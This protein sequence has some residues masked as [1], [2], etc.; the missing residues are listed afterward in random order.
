MLTS[1]LEKKKVTKILKIQ[2]K[3][4]ILNLINNYFKNKKILFEEKKKL[5]KFSAKI[6]LDPYKRLENL[7]LKK[8]LIY[9]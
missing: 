7:L 6:K 2:H 5:D 3:Y 8:K 4:K 9:N 1:Y